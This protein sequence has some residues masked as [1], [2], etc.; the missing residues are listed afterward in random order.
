LETGQYNEDKSDRITIDII[1]EWVEYE[2]Q[3]ISHV[4]KEVVEDV[5][6]HHR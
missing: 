5:L 3:N 6:K 2:S 1:Q 4:G